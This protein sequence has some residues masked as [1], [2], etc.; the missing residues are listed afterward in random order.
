MNKERI[1]LTKIF[2]FDAAHVL[3]NYPGK[4]KNI[5]GHTYFL[6]VT[7]SGEVKNDVNHPFNG[8]IMDFS[9][10]KKWI[11]ESVLQHFDHA[12]LLY[13]NSTTAKLDFPEK[14]KIY[15]ASYTPTCE[16]MLMDI[17]TR[18]KE[19]VPSTIQ[20]SEVRLQETPTSFA[21]WSSL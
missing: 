1:T 8:M 19:S 6:H 17:V 9:E 5:H 11:H 3:E 16:N 2:S 15:F 4:C 12:L 10:L 20:L 7:V 13:K 21:T 18:L 14:E